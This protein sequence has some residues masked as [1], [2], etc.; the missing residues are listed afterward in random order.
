MLETTTQLLF[1]HSNETLRNFPSN[2]SVGAGSRVRSELDAKLLRNFKFH[3][4]DRL[5]CSR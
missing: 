3:L 1:C 4:I 5:A 2:R